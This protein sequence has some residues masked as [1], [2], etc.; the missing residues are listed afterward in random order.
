MQTVILANGDFP[1]HPV[2]SDCLDKA[3]QI[4]CCDGAAAKL[5]A[6]GREPYCIVGDLDSLDPLLRKQY[7]DR[8][9]LC[10]DQETNDLTKAVNWC[11]RHGIESFDILGATGGREDHTLANISLLLDYARK[12]RVRMLTDHGIFIPLCEATE[13][14]CRKGQEISFFS[15]DNR[16][17]LQAT[18]L[19]Y[20]VKDV[21]FDTW[22]K[23][24]LNVSVEER[25]TIRPKG[26]G[27]CFLAF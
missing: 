24:S 17:S 8:L 4:V 25:I 7:A 18:G 5:L 14:A 22:W 16:F 9:Y 15:P 27:L 6:Y 21:V 26:R 1:S 2:P 23:A 10:S 20:E 13:I 3:S 12:Y 11:G 19:Q